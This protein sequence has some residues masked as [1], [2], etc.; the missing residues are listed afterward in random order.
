L[1]TTEYNLLQE[2]AQN[3]GKVLTYQYLL[4]KVWGPEYG[5]ER[6]YLHVYIGHLRAKVEVDHRK[7]RHIISMPGTGYYFCSE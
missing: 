7:P 5:T 4:N 3:A 1:T 2:L 6:E